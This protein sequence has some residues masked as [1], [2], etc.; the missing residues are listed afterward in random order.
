[1]HAFLLIQ[2]T[3]LIKTYKP[4]LLFFYFISIKNKQTWNITYDIIV[5]I[6]RYNAFETTWKK[7]TTGIV[8]LSFKRNSLEIFLANWNTDNKTS[9]GKCNI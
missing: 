2:N 5:V 7:N 6:Y 1:M 9:F 4:L 8:Y 3:W